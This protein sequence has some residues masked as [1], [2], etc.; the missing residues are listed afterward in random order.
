M[1]L[2]RI[3]N[4]RAIGSAARAAILLIYP[5]NDTNRP[6]RLKAELLDEQD[7][8]QR[9]HHSAAIVLRALTNVP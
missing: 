4:Q 9:S 2:R 8:F 7:R 5:E 3:S 6:P 1:I